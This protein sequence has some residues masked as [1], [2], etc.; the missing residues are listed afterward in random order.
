[1]K[2]N[3]YNRFTEKLLKEKQKEGIEKFIDFLIENKVLNSFKKSKEEYFEKNGYILE[4]SLNIIFE[5]PGL[6]SNLLTELNN[7][8]FNNYKKIVKN[9][10]EKSQGLFLR[11]LYDN[12]NPRK[13][14]EECLD[15]YQ[16]DYNI[17]FTKFYIKDD[18]DKNSLKDY[19]QNYFHSDYQHI[20]EFLTGRYEKEIII[21][22]ISIYNGLLNLYRNLKIRSFIKSYLNSEEKLIIENIKNPFPNI[23]I[24]VRSYTIFREYIE[25]IN[26][27]NEKELN[28][29]FYKFKNKKL[30]H[31]ELDFKTYKRWVLNT[32]QIFGEIKDFQKRKVEP[33]FKNNKIVEYLYEKHFK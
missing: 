27:I 30:I 26:K 20:E 23:F 31:S 16:I 12:I 17:D 19:I 33:N 8:F 25:T 24:G 7:I 3:Y 29:I 13:V 15:N 22:R 2:Y 9:E 1:M 18:F 4:N 11:K 21:S 32:Q 10:I 28:Y 5:E 6:K 14:I